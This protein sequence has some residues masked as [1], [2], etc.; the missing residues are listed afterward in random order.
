MQQVENYGFDLLFS[1]IGELVAIV[2]ED[3]DAVVGPRIMRGRDHDACVIGLASEIGDGG[4]GNDTGTADPHT[5]RFKSGGD[6]IANPPARFAC[7]LP[8]DNPGIFVRLCQ[9]TSKCNADGIHSGV[10]EWRITR[11]SADAISTK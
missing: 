1:F 11:N 3:L 9:V 4:R 8:D 6:G 10:I 7:V 5:C 2:S